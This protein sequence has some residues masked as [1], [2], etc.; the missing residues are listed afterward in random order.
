MRRSTSLPADEQGVCTTHFG[1]PAAP[2]HLTLYTIRT[3][4]N[5]LQQRVPC[6]LPLWQG[7][8]EGSI[9]VHL[10]CLGYAE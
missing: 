7:G 2:R 5:K 3:C 10:T 8:K 4:T 9:H 1:A 6:V